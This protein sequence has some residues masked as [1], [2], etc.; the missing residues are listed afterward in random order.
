MINEWKKMQTM[1]FSHKY[2]CLFV[3]KMIRRIEKKTHETTQRP[4]RKVSIFIDFLIDFNEFTL[5]SPFIN[6][7]FIEYLEFLRT[8]IKFFFIYQ[9]SNT[10]QTCD[11]WKV[12]GD[13]LEIRYTSTEWRILHDHGGFYSWLSATLS[14]SK[15][16]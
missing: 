8:L 15:F 1:P 4:S 3:W 13:F 12:A 14:R 2:F 11:N 7:T 6:D 16:Q 5:T 10:Y 9:G